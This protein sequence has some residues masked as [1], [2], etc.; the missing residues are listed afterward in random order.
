MGKYECAKLKEMLGAE[1]SDIAVSEKE[2]IFIKLEKEGR[3]FA[4]YSIDGNRGKLDIVY[5]Y[6]G[7]E[8]EE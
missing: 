7:H 4:V 5:D 2:V 3:K 1:V 6:K 8:I